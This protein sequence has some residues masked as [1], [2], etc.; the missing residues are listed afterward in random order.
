[1]TDLLKRSSGGDGSVTAFF[2][3]VNIIF[4]LPFFLFVSRE[5]NLF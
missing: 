3:G 5:F 2:I 4:F 1:M